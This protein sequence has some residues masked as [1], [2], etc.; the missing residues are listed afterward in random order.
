MRA[1]RD[2]GTGQI[3]IT[4]AGRPVL[5]YNYQIIKPPPGLLGSV[6][7]S[8]RKY[9]VA[10]SDYIHPL[11]GLDGEAL[12]L[13]WP[14]NHPHHRGVY[15]AWPEV[16]FRKMRG[17][18]HALQHVFSRPTGHIQLKSGDAAASIVAENRW[19]W[20]DTTPIV[21]EVATIVAHRADASGRA[22]DLKLEF[23]ALVDGVKIAR[24][25]TNHYGGL[26]IRLAPIANMKLIH[27]ADPPDAQPRRAWSAATGTWTG[28]KRPSLLAVLEKA[29]NPD[30][31][32]DYVEYPALPWFQP[33]FPRAGTRYKLK[34]GH[35]LVLQ[36][37]LW[38]HGNSQVG[39]EQ[40]QHAWN[41]FN[42][43]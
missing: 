40:Y 6:P 20:E 39:R 1:V 15:W 33:A 31:P 26:N 21:R 34:Q 12:T 8:S 7:P 32:G 10:R 23:T 11:F 22:I 43:G 3:D 30:Y 5:R 17:D 2:P 42:G 28:A 38:V 16:D 37:R 41:L 4:E 24:R 35:P 14:P 19:L 29:A 25:G 9:A 36:Y 18:L 27:D 13:D